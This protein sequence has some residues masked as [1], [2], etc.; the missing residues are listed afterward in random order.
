[1]R[2]GTRF[3]GAN[4]TP[5]AVS[6]RASGGADKPSSIGTHTEH[7]GLG[8]GQ[9]LGRRSVVTRSL[10]STLFL[11]AL[12][13]YAGFSAMGRTRGSVVA[14]AATTNGKGKSSLGYELKMSQ[15]DIDEAVKGLP[16][17]SVR[18]TMQAGTER[19]F[20][21]KTVNGYGHDNK[22]DGVYV[23]AV[24]GLPLFDSKAKFDSGTGWPSF[25]APIAPDHV[26]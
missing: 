21:G 3:L 5:R 12:G 1:M 11:A 15:A 19:A 18:V 8:Q 10:A 24:S 23:S 20:T 22:E 25:W 2:I 14:T 13:G 6:T 26:R 9:V 16:D 17:L 4:R 7:T